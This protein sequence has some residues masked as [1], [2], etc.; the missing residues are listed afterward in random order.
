MEISQIARC[1]GKSKKNIKEISK[2][3]RE[4]NDLD[5]IMARDRTLRWKLIST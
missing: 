3:D 2:K 4:I 5:K 1:R